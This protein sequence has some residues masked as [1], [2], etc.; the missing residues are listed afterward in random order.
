MHQNTAINEGQFE[1]DNFTFHICSINTGLTGFEKW[2]H[3]FEHVIGIMFVASLSDYN[4]FLSEDDSRNA[5]IDSIH[6]FHQICLS[7][8]FKRTAVTLFLNKKD[9]FETDIKKHPLTVCFK[10]YVSY[11]DTTDEAERGVGYIRQKFIGKIQNGSR[12]IYT[13]VIS[14][15]IDSSNLRDMVAHDVAHICVNTSLN[16]GGLI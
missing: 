13:H 2:I 5:L 15:Y 10:D 4:K 1:Q 9:E 3:F 14:E 7:E 8:W 11:R 12:Y 6:Q 16:K